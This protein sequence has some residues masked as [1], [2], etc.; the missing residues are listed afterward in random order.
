MAFGQWSL[1][2]N[3]FRHSPSK[4]RRENEWLREA[5]GANQET[6]PRELVFQA[7]A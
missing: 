2:I 6:V 4:A 5:E 3:A 1:K 7:Q